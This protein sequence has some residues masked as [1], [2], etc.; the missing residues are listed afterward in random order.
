MVIWFVEILSGDWIK[1]CFGEG[2]CNIISVCD[3]F[4]KEWSVLFISGKCEC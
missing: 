3:V 1:F 4:Y 2:I